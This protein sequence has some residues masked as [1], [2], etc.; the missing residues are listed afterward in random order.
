MAPPR[1][2]VIKKCPTCSKDFYLCRSYSLRVKF[3][4][5][6]CASNHPDT[7]AKNSARLKKEWGTTRKNQKTRDYPHQIE[8]IKAR[9]TGEN[10]HQYKDDVGYIAVHQWIRRRKP[11][12]A[13]CEHCDQPP[14]DLANL[15]QHEY[16]RD[17]SDY[18]WLCRKC[19]MILDGRIPPSRKGKTPHNKKVN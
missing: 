6:V 8:A 9:M 15:N 19:H 16:T 1:N 18:K 17:P 5:R 2:G 10:N 3:C 12:P 14:M 11:K 7:K 4:S 13:T